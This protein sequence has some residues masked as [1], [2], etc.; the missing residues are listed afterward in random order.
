MKIIYKKKSHTEI[1]HT[2]RM[3]TSLS[4]YTAAILE[5]E[6]ITLDFSLFSEHSIYFMYLFT[7]KN[8]KS[9]TQLELE[10]N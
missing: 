4:F 2:Q 7:T 6:S 5:P 10:N 9:T 1:S 8:K 3:Y